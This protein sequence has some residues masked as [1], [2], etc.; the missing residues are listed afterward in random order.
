MTTGKVG[1]AE[2]V[3]RKSQGR[4][5]G[6]QLTVSTRLVQESGLQTKRSD[7]E[8]QRICDVGNIDDGLAEFQFFGSF[9]D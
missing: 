1:V 9:K 4:F 6:R 7:K 8:F 5:A 2:R 3:R